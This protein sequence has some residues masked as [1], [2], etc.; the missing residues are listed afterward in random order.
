M[1]ITGTYQFTDR[2]AHDALVVTLSEMKTHLKI[3]PSFTDEDDYIEA[4]IIA[5]Q[6][7]VESMTWRYLNENTVSFSDD[8]WPEDNIIYLVRGPAWK[9]ESFTYKNT[10][11]DDVAMSTGVDYNFDIYNEVGRVN[12]ITRPTLNKDVLNPITITYKTRW[13]VF[14]N[15]NIVPQAVKS[16]IKLIGAH[17]YES[18]QDVISGTISPEVPHTS[19]WILN[20]YKIRVF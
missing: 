9:V 3:E 1:K 19:E 15:S 17:W 12:L 5:A 13:N 6:D 14:D 2:A 10:D 8:N 20:P 16:A 4:L 18:R 11:G 7:Q